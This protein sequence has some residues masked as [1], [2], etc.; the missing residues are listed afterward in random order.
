[1]I[2]TK[3]LALIPN[4]ITGP[5]IENILAHSPKIMPSRLCSIAGLTI[6]LANP[7]IGIILPAPPND[8]ILS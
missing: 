8:P 6:E 1:M 3:I 4:T 2:P 5:A 7:V